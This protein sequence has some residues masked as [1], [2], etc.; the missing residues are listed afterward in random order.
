ML[1]SKMR[2]SW[3][4]DLQMLSQLRHS[5]ILGYCDA[6]QSGEVQYVLCDNA[7]MFLSVYLRRQMAAKEGGSLRSGSQVVDKEVYP[8][9]LFN[10]ASALEYLH[11]RN[12][13][14]KPMLHRAVQPDNI[15]ITDRCVL[16]LC[17]FHIAKRLEG[18]KK[19]TQTRVGGGL[20]QC[21]EIKAHKSYGQSVDIWSLG[22]TAVYIANYTRAGKAGSARKLMTILEESGQDARTVQ[23]VC[24]AL[25]ERPEDRPR[26]SQIVRDLCRIHD[27]DWLRSPP[28]K[29]AFSSPL[30]QG[31]SHWGQ[32]G[33]GHG[34]RGHRGRDQEQRECDVPDYFDGQSDDRLEIRSRGRN[35]SS[36][37]TD[38]QDHLQYHGGRSRRG[39]P[40]RDHH[41]QASQSR[42]HYYH[43]ALSPLDLPGETDG[44][45]GLGDSLHSQE[46]LVNCYGDVV[47]QR[48]ETASTVRRNSWTVRETLLVR[49]RR[50][51]P[52]SGGTRGLLGEL[53]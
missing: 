17:A 4:K 2:D 43:R 44:T 8:R 50:Q 29:Q 48:E 11:E 51:L 15:L 24:G 52:Q 3:H 27:E 18:K 19:P 31:Y 39:R 46:E 1:R 6:W 42:A 20:F 13:E 16:K 21:P 12:D 35:N 45:S 14:D 53:R 49:G 26:A 47:G 36:E 33:K 5:N 23:V 28:S 40:S 25:R 30:G 7:R 9:W 38:D 41:Q 37:R 22:V 32:Q 10:I 34:G